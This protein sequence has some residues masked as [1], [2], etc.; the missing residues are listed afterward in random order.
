MKYE[1]TPEYRAEIAAQYQKRNLQIEV[2]EVHKI[3]KALGLEVS[4]DDIVGAEAGNMNAT[5]LAG[6]YVVKINKNP[7]ETKYAAN[8]V[9]SEA[10]PESKVV[11]TVLHDQYGKTEYEVLV[12]ERA[13]GDMWLKKMPEMSE[14]QNKKLFAEV[15]NVVNECR[16]I[17]CTDKFGWVTDII[18]DAEKS[19]FASFPDQLTARLD[20]YVSKLKQ[21]SY[22][23]QENLIQVD[24]YIRTHLHLF[25]KDVASFVHTDLHMGNVMHEDGK[26]TAVIDFDSIQSAPAYRILMSLIGVIDNPAQFV[27]GTPDFESYKG[28]RFEYLYP[29]MKEKLGDLLEE[30]N[31]GLKLNILGMIEG[32]MWASEEWSKQWTK[33]M[34]ENLATNEMVEDGDYSKT[35]YLPIIKK[36]RNS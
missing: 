14:E 3:L 9:V 27:E 13:T 34:V 30:E 23:D 19:G 31:L 8:I 15:L 18:R 12:M 29:V 25:T 26:L 33:E 11:R 7:E 24:E 20:S 21:L 28:R 36:V 22:V 6:K 10:L 32:L 4:P 35:Y 5:F 16:S 17:K 1:D 2:S